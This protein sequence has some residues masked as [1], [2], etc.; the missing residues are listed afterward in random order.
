MSFDTNMQ[1]L[2]QRLIGSKGKTV[3]LTRFDAGAYDAATLTVTHTSASSSVKAIVAPVRFSTKTGT[4]VATS[5]LT[6]LFAALDLSGVPKP[7][8]TVNLA[9]AMYTVDAVSPV[10][11]G[12][13]VATYQL[14]AH[15]G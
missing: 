7:E 3:T 9:G 5:D 10:Y 14:T 13:L 4:M 15:A 11:A 6:F 8:D 1:L 12:E 2:A